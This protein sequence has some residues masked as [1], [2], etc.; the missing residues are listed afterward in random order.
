MPMQTTL[1]EYEVAVRSRAYQFWL[2]E[3][4]P[5]GRH[6]FHW[7]RALASLTPLSLV[8]ETPAPVSPASVDANAKTPRAKANK[9]CGK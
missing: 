8:T 2:E 7:Q 6:D 1:P 4:R 5:E 3:G 9:T